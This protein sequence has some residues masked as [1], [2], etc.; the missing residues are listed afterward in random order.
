MKKLTKLFSV[1]AVLVTVFGSLVNIRHL[2]HAEDTQ[3]HQTK[4]VVHKVLMSKED[5]ERFDHQTAQAIQKYDGT[6]IQTGKFTQ[7]FGQ[8]ATEIAGVN[9]KV[10]KKV[11]NQ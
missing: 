11:D 3:P 10:W 7:Y 6:E 2:V 8:S 9:F 1:F 4:V 5:F